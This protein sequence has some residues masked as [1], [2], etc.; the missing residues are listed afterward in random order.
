VRGGVTQAIGYALFEEMLQHPD[1][2]P[3][4]DS[5]LKFRVPHLRETPP[6]EPLFCGDPDPFAPYGAKAL[7]EPPLV[8]TAAAIANAVYDAVGVRI[9]SLPLTPAR[10]LAALAA[11][12]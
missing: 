9:R 5:F 8:P 7:G 11:A 10:V 12:R 2:R 6:I 4:T 3:I 1:G